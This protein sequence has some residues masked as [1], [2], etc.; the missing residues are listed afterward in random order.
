MSEDLGRNELNL[1]NKPLYVK[2]IAI[3]NMFD[4]IFAIILRNVLS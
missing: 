2:F 3:F 4:I 1:K